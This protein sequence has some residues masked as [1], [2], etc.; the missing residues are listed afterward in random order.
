MMKKA[1]SRKS[2]FQIRASIAASL[3]D[4]YIEAAEDDRPVI[5]PSEDPAKPPTF[6]AKC[7][8]GGKLILAGIKYPVVVDL[9]GL[10]VTAKSRPVLREHETK[11]NIGHTTDIRNDFRK[12]DATGVISVSNHDSKEVVEASKNGFPWQISIGAKALKV[13][14]VPQGKSVTVNGQTF[15]GPVLV[16]RQ[17]QL[18]EIS[19]VTLGSDD[20]T[21]VR[22]AATV[23]KTKGIPNMNEFEKWIQAT[24]GEDHEL[25]D[26]QLKD[27]QATF[28]NAQLALKPGPGGKKPADDET[29]PA[30]LL[31]AKTDDQITVDGSNLT[32]VL[33]ASIAETTPGGNG[34]NEKW[35]MQLWDVNG[36]NGQFT[37]RGDA[38]VT[39]GTWTLKVE[40]GE[41]PSLETQVQTAA[42]PWNASPAEV[43][44]AITA[45]NTHPNKLT[46]LLGIDDIS[47]LC[48]P[49]PSNE[50]AFGMSSRI[51]AEALENARIRGSRI[52]IVSNRLSGSFIHSFPSTRR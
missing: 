7:Y 37:I 46:T 33:A 24:F 23:A 9:K 51:A 43:Q 52:S 8:N 28:D 2:D 44:A 38:D 17:S 14:M 30:V 3:K 15:S 40:R 49:L 19:F 25:T 48:I 50:K 29:D 11:R 45:G 22:L 4:V 18:K 12:L 16:A 1:Q 26:D 27:L 31:Q 10:Q 42:I 5:A 35:I 20:D 39:G 13:E 36:A 6:E 32:G 41:H 21:E 34:I 47:F